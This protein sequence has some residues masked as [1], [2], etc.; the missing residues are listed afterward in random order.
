MLTIQ[1]VKAVLGDDIANALYEHFP[2]ETLPIPKKPSSVRFLTIDERNQY[3]FNLAN[4]GVKY[5]LIA[6][7]VELSKGQI[8]RIIAKEIKK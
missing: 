6:E 1:K 4:N 3:I 2:G 7:E 5:D 8:S